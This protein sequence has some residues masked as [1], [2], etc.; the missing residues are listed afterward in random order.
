VASRPPIGVV[1]QP[2]GASG[3]V[4]PP[5]ERLMVDTRGIPGVAHQG[6]LWPPTIFQF[7]FYNFFKKIYI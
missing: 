5:P 4:A 6:W 1:G 7:F 2:H 3:V